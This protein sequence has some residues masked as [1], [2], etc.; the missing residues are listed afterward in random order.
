MYTISTQE[1][2]QIVYPSTMD[3]NDYY[4]FILNNMEY[5]NASTPVSY[6]GAGYTT[7]Y[8]SANSLIENVLIQYK[9]GICVL[10][11][12][13]PNGNRT[14][15]IISR[16]DP[17]NL[18]IQQ[19]YSNSTN[20]SDDSIQ[21][22]KIYENYYIGFTFRSY[23]SNGYY[24]CTRFMDV[25]RIV[26]TGSTY[27]TSD[28][29]EYKCYERDGIIDN[30]NGISSIATIYKNKIYYY[31]NKFSGCNVMVC[32]PEGIMTHKINFKTKTCQRWNNPKLITIPSFDITMTNIIDQT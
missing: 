25:G 12:T 5:T 26:K 2:K 30:S 19:Y 9:D 8:R 22:A 23:Y 11:S 3:N 6:N 20:T 31:G 21:L 13:N 27:S 10:R 32:P 29:V 18:M 16:Y 4:G 7:N 1:F 15:L 28:D 14:V 17:E 24:Q